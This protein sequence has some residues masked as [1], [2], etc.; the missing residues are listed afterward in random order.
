MDCVSVEAVVVLFEVVIKDWLLTKPFFIFRIFV[1]GNMLVE[2]DV[3]FTQL[4]A[5]AFFRQ[6]FRIYFGHLNLIDGSKEINLL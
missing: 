4:V 1:L 2:G 6:K 5:L 3:L